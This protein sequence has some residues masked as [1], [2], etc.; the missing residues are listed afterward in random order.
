MRSSRSVTPTYRHL[1]VECTN[2]ACGHRYAACEERFFTVLYS[3]APSSIA[4][5]AVGLAMTEACRRQLKLKRPANDVGP[6]G[7]EVPLPAAANDDC[8]PT[9]ETG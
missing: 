3:I 8:R 6:G 5:P 2:A 1:N 7:P 4:N 9:E